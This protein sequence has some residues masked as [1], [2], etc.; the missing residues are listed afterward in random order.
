VNV[1]S[2]VAVT[3]GLVAALT[4]TNAAVAASSSESDQNL[5]YSRAYIERAYD[6]LSHDMADYGGHRVAAMNDLSQ[7]RTDLTQALHY[8]RNPED[9]AIP[10]GVRAEDA[11]LSNF[12]RTQHGSTENLE[13]TRTY[14]EHAIDMLQKDAPDY[15]GYRL[16][17]IA[18]LGAARAQLGAAVAY[19]NAHRTGQGDG[20]GGS[21]DNLRYSRLYLDRAIDMLNHD[22]H[23]Y[24]GHREAAIAD[25]GGAQNDLTAALRYDSNH[26]DAVVPTHVMA[27]DEDLES[28]FV[29]GQFGSNQN[30]EFVRRYVERAIDMLTRDAHDYGGY[31]VKAIVALQAGRQQ[32][33]LALKVPH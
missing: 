31:R 17:A 33:L 11:D 28:Y 26:A 13:F 27:G 29:R 10:G 25:I 16:K 19:R 3:A 18:A 4:T 8:D 21:D 15:G 20:S 14:V 12:I 1:K 2:I 9:A 7:A 6:M 24:A 5:R 30:I 23:D 22:M 32:L